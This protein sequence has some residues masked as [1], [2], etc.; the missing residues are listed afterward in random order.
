MNDIELYLN[1]LIINI[2]QIKDLDK[3][4]LINILYL[5]Y[6]Q[7]ENMS[8]V[9]YNMIEIILFK[10]FIYQEEKE[11]NNLINIYNQIIKE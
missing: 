9:I 4:D 8:S 2:D 11:E 6:T 3:D 5:L 7:K 1:Q 10:F